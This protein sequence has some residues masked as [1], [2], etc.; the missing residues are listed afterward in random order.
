ML[1]ALVKAK[2]IRINFYGVHF[3]SLNIRL[4]EVMLYSLHS[5]SLR[6]P[7]WRLLKTLDFYFWNIV[8]L[9]PRSNSRS[10]LP[11]WTLCLL[12][13]GH[14]HC[15]SL[16]CLLCCLPVRI[17]RLQLLPM[18]CISVFPPLDLP[19][20]VQFWFWHA[21]DDA[22]QLGRSWTEIAFLLLLLPFSIQILSHQ[23]LI[24][25]TTIQLYIP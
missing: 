9:F 20:W 2:L 18:C 13:G 24:C 4:L 7:K 22:L 16:L 15:I 11:G 8:L 23:F 21:V 5:E 1:S 3:R 12:C 17:R 14:L 6:Q 25:Q 10:V 19:I